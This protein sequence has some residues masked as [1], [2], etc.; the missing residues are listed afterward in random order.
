[1]G[2]DQ[3]CR[4]SILTGIADWRQISSDPADIVLSGGTTHS[5][6]LAS[7]LVVAEL[8]PLAQACLEIGS[9]QLRNRA[10]VAGNLVTASPANDT[11]SAL[12]ALDARLE[13]V[14]A[15][16]STGLERR[17]LPLADFFTGFRTTALVPGELVEAIRV[18]RPV[19]GQ[20]GNWVKLG[21]RK[22]QAIS[23]VHAGVVVE[24]APDGVVRNAR[25]ALGSVAPTVE[26]NDA[27]AQTLIGSPLTGAVIQAAA[28]A[29]AASVTP[30]DDVRATAAYRSDAIVTVLRRALTVLAADRQ[31]ETW[32]RRVPLL[33][34]RR[35]DRSVANDEVLDAASEVAVTVNGR[36]VTAPI[37]ATGLLLDWLR[38]AAGT[39]TKE[40]CAEGEC[41]ACTVQLD[42]EAVMSC[43]VH[44]AQAV[45]SDV[46][47]IEDLAD[48]E[49]PSAMQASFVDKF[50]VQCGYCIPGFV[51]AATVL[52]AEIDSPTK[53]EIELGLSG[54][55]CRCT[56]YYSIIEAVQ[57]ATASEDT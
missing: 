53:P 38:E 55:L 9:P 30:I 12:L 50:A 37:P 51:M 18:P 33:S 23:V 24:L 14:R 8:L 45:G 22:A 40:G 17:S 26:L 21:L 54:N 29:A 27:A 39:G 48:G 6:V 42:G 31:R 43:L 5:D 56:G 44:A 13:L 41:G 57:A 20:R 28:D 11:L 7:A 49:T 4:C 10:T 2:T 3:T 1:M 47:T 46:R 19:A 15:G 32:P 35:D 16:Q 36:S 34:E 25:I 52:V